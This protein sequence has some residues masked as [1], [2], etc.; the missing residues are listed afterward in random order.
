MKKIKNFIV[1]IVFP[2]L[3]LCLLFFNG[4]I[5]A[6]EYS[7][8][9][10]DLSKLKQYDA[11]INSNQNEVKLQPGSKGKVR[12]TIK[13]TGTMTWIPLDKNGIDVS[14]HLM[15]MN[16]NII[17]SDGER[18]SLPSAVKSG[19]TVQVDMS[20]TAPEKEGNYKVEID[21]VH[22]GVTWFKQ[23]GSSTLI[24]NLVVVK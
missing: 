2:I 6:K 16:N 10:N 8:D 19:E 21:M 22:E 23:K 17:K 13:N 1:F 9:K 18:T 15:D 14:Y 3:V 7:N 12:L 24:I 11:I 20:I 5:A 4:K